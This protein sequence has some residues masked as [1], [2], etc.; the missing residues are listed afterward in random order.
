MLS[1]IFININS[2][3]SDQGPF[4]NI[5]SVSHRLDPD[6]AQHFVWFDLGPNCVQRLSVEY[7]DS[8]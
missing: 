8:F 3:V 1:Y 2:Q 7:T 6:Q 5:I 4:S